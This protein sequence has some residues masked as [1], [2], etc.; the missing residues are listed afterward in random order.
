MATMAD[1][2]QGALNEVVRLLGPTFTLEV[3]LARISLWRENQPLRIETD[4]M[5]IGMSGYIVALQ[6]CDLIC[7]RTGLDPVRRISV[8]LHEVAHILLNHVA[9]NIDN[10]MVATYAEFIHHRDL[11]QAACRGESVHRNDTRERRTETL[12]AALLDI[13]TR[14]E[15]LFAELVY[16]SEDAA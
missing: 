10:P 15:C 6:D 13:V 3:L 7:T 4:R 14:G 11:T 8:I 9:L 12:A 1:D 16:G 2:I 5:P